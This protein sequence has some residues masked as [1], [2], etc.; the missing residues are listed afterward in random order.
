MRRT[1]VLAGL[2][3]LAF[4]TSSAAPARQQ[5][6]QNVT[7]AYRH[8]WPQEEIKLA[9]RHGW[10]QEEIKVAYRHGWPQEEIK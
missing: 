2:A 8:G 7:V 3:A 5:T 4:V 9:Y 6:Q 1:L 10:P